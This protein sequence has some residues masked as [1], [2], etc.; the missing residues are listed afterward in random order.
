MFFAMKRTISLKLTLSENQL[1]AF[2]E[3]QEKF[4]ATCNY[5]GQIA[6]ENKER[7]RVKLHHLA[8]YLVREKFPEL[9]AQMA[10]NAIAKVAGALR[11]L[12]KPKEILFRKECSVHF[13]KRTYS[14]KGEFLSLFTLQKRARLQLD[15][16]SFHQGFL[17]QGVAK[18]AEL[19]RKG[20]R[21]FFHLVLDLPDV[22]FVSSNQK[23]GVDFGENVLAA[24]STGKLFGGGTL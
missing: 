13:D 4:S 17:E 16:S 14:L 11:V 3:L 2:T 24:L 8:Y 5:I 20:N 15:I 22:P 12:K 18:E 10:C 21:W 6:F 1:Q 19:V 23:I 9:G 7:N